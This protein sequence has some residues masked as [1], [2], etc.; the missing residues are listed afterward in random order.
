[1]V[2][3]REKGRRYYYLFD[4]KEIYELFEKHKLKVIKK[5]DHGVN[6]SFIIEKK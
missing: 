2:S 1:M 6:I 4:E 3:W 5:L